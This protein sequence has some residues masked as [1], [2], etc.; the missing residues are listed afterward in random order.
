MADMQTCAAEALLHQLLKG[1]RG[2]LWNLE[3]Y[4]TFVQEMLL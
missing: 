4:V 2:D 3:K 1:F